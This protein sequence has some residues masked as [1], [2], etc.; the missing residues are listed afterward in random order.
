M[1][2]RTTLLGCLLLLG[3]LWPVASGWADHR[4]V[5][6]GVQLQG[7]DEQALERWAPVAWHLNKHLPNYHFELVALTRTSTEAAVDHGGLGLDFVITDPGLYVNLEVEHGATRIATKVSKYDGHALNVLASAIF[8][9]SDRVDINHFEDLEDRRL[10][11]LDKHSF[12]G[13]YLA[14]NALLQ[15][16]LTAGS[17]FTVSFTDNDAWAVVDAVLEGRA[18]A[19]VLPSGV[20]EQLSAFESLPRERFK[21]LEQRQTPFFPVAHSTAL[22]PEWALAKLKH[23][24]DVLARKVVVR[25]RTGYLT[26][27]RRMDY[28]AQLPAGAR[29]A[30][31]HR[32][33]TLRRLPSGHAGQPAR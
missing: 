24:P 21:V 32:R 7:D 25:P 8:T 14:K 11:A 17:D 3:F 28:L 10:V 19:G 27:R 5:R 16:G 12:E 4:E 6:I 33:A 13:W 15:T 26:R 29:S 31:C 18:D 22:Y 1:N 2:R 23:T 30:A 9:N 20:I